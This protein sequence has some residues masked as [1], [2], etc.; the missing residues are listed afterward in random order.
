MRIAYIDP[1]GERVEISLV[2]GRTIVGSLF[3]NQVVIDGD[4]VEPIHALVEE[5]E[6]KY[7][8]VD[9]DS[10][11]GVFC[12]DKRI[13]VETK[14]KSGD[15]I[16]IGKHI[17]EVI[18]S[19]VPI[20]PPAVS[21]HLRGEFQI[22]EEDEKDIERRK[23]MMLFS[24]RKARPSGNVLECVAYWDHT[25][26]D[27]EHYIPQDGEKTK[28]TIGDPT[29]ND[30]IAVG[31]PDIQHHTLALLSTSGGMKLR[32]LEGMEARLRIEG[33][34]KSVRGKAGFKLSRR[35]IAHV[36]YGPIRYFLIF[37]QPPVLNLPPFS[38]KDPLL[39]LLLTVFFLFYMAII[40][41][42]WMVEPKPQEKN[43]DD[44]WALVQLPRKEQAPPP[45]VVQ[46]QI[47]RVDEVKETPKT[48][49]RPEKR[50][51]KP[52]PA[53]VKEKPQQ[54]K[55]VENPVP[56]PEQKAVEALRRPTPAT[57]KQERSAGQ[58][59]NDRSGTA[60][61]DAKKPDFRKA[62]P[63]NNN[64]AAQS[65]GARGAGM[66][67]Q[68]GERKGTDGASHK[69]VEDV[70]NKQ[71]S[72]VNLDKLGVG[73]GNILSKTGVGAVNTQFKSSAG[74][75]GGGAGSASRTYGLG[76]VGNSSSLGLAGSGSAVNNFGAGSGGF[77]SGQ[78]GSGG[79]GGA[80]I[81]DG[82]GRGQGG[83]GRS[84]ISVPAEDGVISGGLTRQEIMAVINSNLNQIRHCYERLLQR[85]PNASGRMKVDFSINAQGRVSSVNI[86]EGTITDSTMRGCVTG[87]V[88]RWAFPRPRGASQVDVSY[89]FVFTPL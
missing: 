15:K 22:N 78:G 12:N 29:K 13:D 50:D 8:L 20:M 37:V 36:K 32:L 73:V 19:S 28:V 24:P 34:V 57:P 48:P 58:S 54:T 4:D 35:D 75:A 56:K 59:A 66:N 51:I 26:L 69:G 41:Y 65:G 46:K 62:G 27:V 88:R 82:M 86:S 38:R 70:N 7:I 74:G 60:S 6:G 80:G 16:R 64:T 11:A 3:S 55:P 18:E 53:E 61:A 5:D 81:G 45:V 77:G 84:D 33:E 25:I 89:P 47:V 39:S 67:Q 44:I 10:D 9:L 52:A 1:T 2:G 76:G 17:L 68:G 71:A 31:D 43:V 14:L 40:P 30:F 83:R 85:S 79:L 42:M 21:E 23:K 63:K 72:G 87:A 49:P